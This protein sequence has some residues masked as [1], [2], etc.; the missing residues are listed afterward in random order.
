MRLLKPRADGDFELVS[1]DNDDDLPPY[2]IL[3]HTWTEGQEVTYNELLDGK[4]RHKTGFEKI[5]FC[6]ERAAADGL[7][8]FWVDTC[9]IDKST[10]NELNTAINSMFRWY[11]R[12]FR[13]YV[14]LSDV[15][16]PVEIPN[17]PDFPVKWLEVFRRSRWF[18]RGWTLQEL[19]APA[20]V[21]FFSKE[22]KGLGDK[23]S[24]EREIQQATKIPVEALRGKAFAEFSVDERMSWAAAR[25][26][27][28]KEDQV[29][30]LLGLF[31]VFLPLIYGEGEAHAT[32]RLREEI[33]KRHQGQETQQTSSNRYAG[34]PILA[35]CATDHG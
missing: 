4:G 1:F 5:R 28:L 33:Q 25:T 23:I 12:S 32:L 34:K 35:R 6:G 18:K 27:T 9:C 15:S 31:E 13:C 29:Y 8:Y 21:E 3:S 11:Q 2:A 30:C 20:T 17:A 19:L 26:T 7:Q 14:Y 22:G 10:N 16:I 24:L